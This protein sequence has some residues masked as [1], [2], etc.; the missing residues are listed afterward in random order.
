MPTPETVFI[1][2]TLAAT[3]FFYGFAG[4]FIA[5]GACTLARP[6]FRRVRGLF[7]WR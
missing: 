6:I 1:A 7:E 4:G 5:I 3:A 2:E